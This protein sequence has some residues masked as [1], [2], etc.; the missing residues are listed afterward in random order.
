MAVASVGLAVGDGGGGIEPAQD[1]DGATC[2][3]GG[4]KQAA[5]TR[6]PPPDGAFAA[7]AEVAAPNG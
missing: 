1:F 4:R 3:R 2:E 7:A 5:T 6:S